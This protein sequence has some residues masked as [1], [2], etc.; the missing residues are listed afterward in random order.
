MWRAMLSAAITALLVLAATQDGSAQSLTAERLLTAQTKL[1][2]GLIERLAKAGEPG[3]NVIVSPGG[4]AAI[5]ALLDLGAD[6]A[7]RKS[8]HAALAFPADGNAATDLGGVRAT[9]SKV[10]KGIKQKD[11]RLTLANAV[12]ID[13]KAKP[14]RNVLDRMRTTGARIAVEDLSKQAT[15]DSINA[16]VK[17]R[18]RG[19]I[20]SILK[21]PPPD[22]GLVALSAMYFK[23]VWRDQFD[24]DNTRPQPFHTV[25]QAKVDVP[26]MRRE[27]NAQFRENEEFVGIELEYK[28]DR[29]AMVI[30]T[31]KDRPR[32][33]ADFAS[34]S[35]WIG[36]GEFSPA[37]VDLSLPR[38]KVDEQAELL[39]ALQGMGLAN[40]ATAFERLAREPQ[41]IAAISQKTF[42]AVDE[43]GTEAAAVTAVGIR[44]YSLPDPPKTMIVDKPFLFALRDRLSGLI[45]L[46]GYIGR[47]AS[48]PTAS[49]AR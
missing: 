14:I 49:L 26:M 1:S 45:L 47:P 8:M 15:I 46:S 28:S 36:G 6:D 13:P 21:A 23:S 38:F 48:G 37:T 41:V 25:D 22:P 19:V 18:T 40:H 39:E 27:L 11:T 4:L 17:Q 42:L 10:D 30:V 43:E 35:D 31:S 7:M 34:V 3:R 24:K 5:L 29:F 33:A 9:V 44:P 20:P 16:W 12:V 2:S 32:P